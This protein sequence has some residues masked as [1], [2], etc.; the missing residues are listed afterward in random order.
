MLNAVKEQYMVSTYLI[1]YLIHSSQTGVGL[2]GFQ[3]NIIQNAGYD[4]WIS[5]IMAGLSLHLILWMI[6]RM[7]RNPSK[8]LTDIHVINFGKFLGNILSILTIGYFFLLA[9][10]VFRTYIDVIQVWVFP[11]LKTWELNI[12]LAIMIAYIISGGFRTIT[13]IS[14]FGVIIPSIL[15]LMIFFPLQYA[16]IRNI[17]PVFNHSVV[18]LL[19][20][21]KSSSIIFIGFEALLVYFPLI[22]DSS[23]TSKWAHA[24]LGYTTLLYALV[25]LVT[26]LYFSQGQLRHTLWPTLVM[27]KI[28]ELPFIERAEFIFIFAW[29]LVILPA[30][31]IPLWCCTRI[32]K[33]I[34]KITPRKSLFFFLAIIYICS[35]FINDRLKVDVLGSITSDI[36]FY[37]VYVYIPILFIFFLFRKNRISKG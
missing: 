13:G 14:F 7:V 20:S 25:T 19:K 22:K 2:L 15:L 9:L 32:S 8:D 21:S 29:L 5:V 11:M 1:F 4:A 16:E 33:K 27:T 23:K 18:D 35:L 12:G 26:F 6:L 36:G 3:K 30:V 37:F 28:V 10:V 24:A 17:I 34:F 31:C